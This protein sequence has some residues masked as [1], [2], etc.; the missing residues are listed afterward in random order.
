MCKFVTENFYYLVRSY[1]FININGLCNIIT[2]SKSVRMIRS[3]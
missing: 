3:F 2:R 1:V